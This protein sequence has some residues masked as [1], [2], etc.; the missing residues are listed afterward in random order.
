MGVTLPNN[1]Y[2]DISLVGSDAELQ[3]HTNL[4]TCCSRHQGM[5]RGDWYGPYNEDRLPFKS[6]EDSAHA[7][8][9]VPWQS[10]CYLV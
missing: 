4:T 5:D 8:L 2:V 3:C 6:E 1:S 9:R 7:I 10:D